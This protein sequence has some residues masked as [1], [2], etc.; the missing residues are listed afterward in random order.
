M[1]IPACLSDNFMSLHSLISRNH[2][3][4]NTCKHMPYMRLTVCSWRSVI[5]CI[6]RKILLLINTL[7]KYFVFFPEV[8]YL[9]FMFNKVKLIRNFLVHLHYPFTNIVQNALH[10]VFSIHYHALNCQQN[11]LIL[12]I[13]GVYYCLLK[14]FKV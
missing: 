13:F 11:R 3:L 8:K 14:V 4:D 10:Q 12:S 9:L 5:K 7:F 6:C 2:I 1:S